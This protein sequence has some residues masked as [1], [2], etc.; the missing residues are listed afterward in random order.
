MDTLWIRRIQQQ[1]HFHHKPIQKICKY[2]SFHLKM[3]FTFS[4]SSLSFDQSTHSAEEEKD[5]FTF[6]GKTNRKVSRLQT[7]LSFFNTRAMETFP[8]EIF[9]Q[10]F[11]Y[12]DI[13]TIFFTIR[14]LCQLF[15]SIVLNYDRCNFQLKI[16]SKARFDVLCQRLPPQNI[17]SLTLYNNEQI[18]DQISTFLQQVHLQQLSRLHSIDLD[19]IKEF[20]LSYLRKR[21][22]LDL[23]RSFS[24]RITKHDDISKEIT[25]NYLSTIVRQPTLRNLYLNI[26]NNRISEISWPMNCSIQCLIINASIQ[27]NDLIKIFSCSSRLTRLII[28]KTFSGLRI[29]NREGY[30]FPQLKS[31]I[32]EEVNSTIDELESFLLLT[33]SLSYLKLIGTV[34]ILDG[35][36]WEDFLQVNLPRL[37]QLQFVFSFH[38]RITQT[39]EDFERKIQSFRSPFWVEDKKWFVQCQWYP[40]DGSKYEFYSIPRCKSSLE[41]DFDWIKEIISTGGQAF[42]RT[43]I[44]QITLRLRTFVTESI[45]TSMNFLDFPNV[46]KLHLRFCGRIWNS[47][48]NLSRMINLSQ[49]VEIELSFDHLDPNNVDLL[50]ENLILLKESS[51]LSTLIIRSIS[52]ERDIYPYLKRIFGSIPRHIKY[53]QIPIRDVEHIPMIIEHCRQLR[54]LQF[55]KKSVSFSEKIREWFERNTMGPIISQSDEYDTI[56]IGPYIPQ[57]I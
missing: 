17:R 14:P 28:K 43:N 22:H 2:F 27:L 44:E 8:V 34:D 31:L 36:R 26:E 12:L 57:T 15:Q 50:C 13:E 16:A 51:K 49:L 48:M 30:S 7:K 18:P 41:M 3:T 1:I 21:I 38:Q 19:G 4:F 35:K 32:I 10:I 56:W 46:T 5:F 42:Q 25:L 20:Q 37:D 45:L 54:V 23:L 9:H 33:P 52:D 29:D 55:L 11:D 24:I 6:V 53:F 39:R 47:S 40:F